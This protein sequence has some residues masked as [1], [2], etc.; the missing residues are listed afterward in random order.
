MNK[1][2]GFNLK[3]V[4]KIKNISKLSYASIGDVTKIYHLLYSN[5]SMW[6]KRK[7]EKMKTLIR[8]KTGNQNLLL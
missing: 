7:R 3:T 6:L 8:S 1:Q 2:F 4:T 5:A